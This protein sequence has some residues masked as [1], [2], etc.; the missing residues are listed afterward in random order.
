MSA[1]IARRWLEHARAD[2]KTAS[3]LQLEQLWAVI[4]TAIGGDR[5][6]GSGAAHG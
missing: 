2:L 1:E 6:V 3:A 5:A 4:Q